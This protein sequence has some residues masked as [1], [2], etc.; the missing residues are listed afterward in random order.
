VALTRSK[1]ELFI[2][3][4]PDW[5]TAPPKN[6]QFD[7]SGADATRTASLTV[8]PQSRNDDFFSLCRKARQELDEE[9]TS[10]FK[11]KSSRER[12]IKTVIDD[13]IDLGMLEDAGK[14]KYTSDE[15]KKVV[16]S[17]IENYWSKFYAASR[18]EEEI[19]DDF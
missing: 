1:S 18:Q 3:G 14:I 13:D 19:E 9:L 15:N 5:Y 12:F 11:N 8:E 17:A 6:T 7:P 2:V 4:Y 10:I 16:Y